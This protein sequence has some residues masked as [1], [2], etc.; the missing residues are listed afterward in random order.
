[1]VHTAP[2]HFGSKLVM[3]GLEPGWLD[4]IFGHK[5]GNAFLPLETAQDHVG[6]DVLA[7]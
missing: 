6:F 7:Q 5:A 3:T 2:C 1:V 4:A